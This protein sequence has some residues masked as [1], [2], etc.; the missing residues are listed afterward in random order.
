MPYKNPDLQKIIEQNKDLQAILAA[1]CI[2]CH[3]Q[4]TFHLDGCTKG[5]NEMRTK[6]ATQNYTVK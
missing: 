1:Q 3:L 2:T 6:L 5:K 4:R